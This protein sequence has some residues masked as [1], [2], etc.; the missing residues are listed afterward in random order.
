MDK[1]KVTRVDDE[2]VVDSED[3]ERA[4]RLAEKRHG[5]DPEVETTIRISSDETLTV[6]PEK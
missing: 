3:V 6:P 2:I 4:Q 1:Q 5:A